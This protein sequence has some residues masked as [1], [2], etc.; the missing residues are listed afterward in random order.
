[1]TPEKLDELE[2][3]ADGLRLLDPE[4]V[5]VKERGL[6]LRRG[7]I[8][9]LIATARREAA[10]REAL[11]D[12]IEHDADQQDNCGDWGTNPCLRRIAAERV[13]LSEVPQ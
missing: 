6:V 4:V 12:M 5:L 2:R 13:L 10:L 7:D 1:M 8:A 3:L 9:D 11:K